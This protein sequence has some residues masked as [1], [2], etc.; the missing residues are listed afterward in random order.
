MNEAQMMWDLR[1]EYVVEIIGYY[2]CKSHFYII[3]ERCL[4]GDL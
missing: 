3:M 2:E 1:S 4:N